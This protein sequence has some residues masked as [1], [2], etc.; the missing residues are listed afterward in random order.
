MQ[1]MKYRSTVTIAVLVFA[2]GVAAR[3]ISGGDDFLYGLAIGLQVGAIVIF[4]YY[5]A[6][7]I[8]DARTRGTGWS[9]TQPKVASSDAG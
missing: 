9:A 1:G 7:L 6:L 5:F 8:R 4:A 2:A 3:L